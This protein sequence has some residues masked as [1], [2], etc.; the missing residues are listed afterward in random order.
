MNGTV[1]PCDEH[2]NMEHQHTNGKHGAGIQLSTIE[3]EENQDVSEPEKADNEPKEE[4]DKTPLPEVSPSHVRTTYEAV[5]FCSAI[6]KRPKLS[7]GLALACHFI[8]IFITLILFRTGY[9]ILPLEFD[10]LPLSLEDDVDYRR[11]LAWQNKNSE[12]EIGSSV[13][14]NASVGRVEEERSQVTDALSV[15]FEVPGGN[16]FTK[17]HLET[18]KRVQE[19]IFN[20]T[21]Y[22]DNFCLLMAGQCVPPTSII[23]YFDGKTAAKLSNPYFNDPTFSNIP[24]ILNTANNHPLLK[25]GLQAFLGKNSEISASRAVSSITTVSIMFAGPLAGYQNVSHLE[26]E[27]EAKISKFYREK[28]TPLLDNYFRNGVDGM[29]VIYLSGTAIS[30]GISGQAM[31]DMMLVIG[32]LVFIFGF[33]AFQTGSFWVTGW[34][35]FSIVACF[36]STNLIYRIVLDFQYL[37]TFHILS[38]FIILGI[39]ADDIFVFYD[40][41][42]ECGFR[43]YPSI[44]HRLSDCYRRASAAMFF[45]SATTAVAFFVS[46]ASPLLGVSSF[47]VFSG[48]L[49]IVNYLSVIIF[50][51]TVVVTYHL[52]WEKFKCCCCC[53]APSHVDGDSSTEVAVRQKSHRNHPVV[54]FFRGPFFNFISHKFIRLVMIAVSLIVVIVFGYFASQIQINEEQVK[55][56]SETTNIGKALDRRSNAFKQV[57]TQNKVVVKI[58]WGLGFRDMSVCHK[59]DYKCKGNVVWDDTFDLNPPPVQMAL[60]NF[61][62]K[63][64]TNLTAQQI[65]DLKIARDIV[66]GELEIRCFMDDLEQFLQNENNATVSGSAK[67]PPGTDYTLPTSEIKI[68]DF[69]SKNPLIYNVTTLNDY[70]YRYFEK[71]M[72]LEFDDDP[73]MICRHR[74]FWFSD[75]FIWNTFPIKSI[76]VFKSNPKHPSIILDY[77]LHS[78]YSPNYRTLNPYAQY[79]SLLGSSPLGGSSSYEIPGRGGMIYGTHL[80]YAA[81]SINTTL[82]GST[83]GYPTGLPVRDKWEQFVTEELKELPRQLR[84]GFQSTPSGINT[85]HWLKVQKSLASSAINGIIIGICIAYPIL[86]LATKNLFVAGFAVLNICF[87][88]VSVVGVIPMAGWKLGVLESLNLVLVVGLSV[89]Y[90]VHLAE[91]YSRS[92]RSDRLGRVHEMLD[93]VGISII[94]GACTTLGASLFMFFAVILFFTQF[95]IFLFCTIGFSIFYSLLFFTA[96]LCTLGPQGE[97]GS[98]LP[99]GRWIKRKFK[100][101]SVV[102]VDCAVCDGKGFYTPECEQ[103]NGSQ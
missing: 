13:P 80:R 61:C 34:A 97:F 85:W 64:K 26:A 32:S 28:L 103:V 18:I 63:L 20:M 75:P 10:R 29:D 16:V 60:L 9:N 102:D 78:G 90:V 48:V 99:F 4:Q 70:F 40:T 87:I 51:P 7:F 67:Y 17:S 6:V 69:M 5:A 56:M 39:G 92:V 44:A 98:I 38:V 27:Q 49:V 101:R 21:E 23:Q 46:G 82:V 96:V 12:G 91:G 71:Q 47:G 14:A 35:V 8:V 73:F 57:S 86:L 22:Q 95:G 45:T 31:S 72:L 15:M 65:D 50:F 1:A 93:Q 76:D 58:M 2:T 33:M 11:G 37:G 19:E 83:L 55:F 52:Y 59:T 25:K 24:G 53:P 74:A 3:N 42:K 88:A 30:T 43:K 81:I 100:G 94:S 79:S 36:F 84:S 41:W 54:R 77:W 89:D 62:Q 66:T 68:Q